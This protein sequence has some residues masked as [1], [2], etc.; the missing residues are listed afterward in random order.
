MLKEK[1]NF[2]RLFFRYAPAF[3]IHRREIE[4][5]RQWV[6]YNYMKKFL[7]YQ[8]DYS[9][10]TVQKRDD[11]EE[12]KVV[13]MYWKQ[14]EEN[15]PNLVKK[16]IESIRNIAGHDRVVVLNENTVNDFIEMP[17][18]IEEKHQ[19]GII[20]EALYSDLLRISLLIHYGGTWCDATC[21]MTSYFPK[22]V[23]KAPMFFFQTD[24]MSGSLV[25]S[26]LSNWFIKADK[27]NE[28]LIALRNILF[29]YYRRNSVIPHYY[30]FHITLSLLVDTNSRLKELWSNIPY[31]SN[32]N[33]HVFHFSVGDIYV[34]EKYEHI[35]NSCFIHKLSYKFNPDLLSAY[36]KN[37]IQH[38]LTIE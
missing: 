31:V 9:F 15:A 21:F 28:L 37:N 22:Y 35:L 36:P 3:Y 19:R 16:C 6:A 13:W 8:D 18:F 27:G 7:K 17:D 38:F 26:K 34:Q 29:N 12:N 10:L 11:I 32:M 20:K 33:P 2:K 1:L 25:P 30:I 24:K 4:E 14:G 5:K 23:E